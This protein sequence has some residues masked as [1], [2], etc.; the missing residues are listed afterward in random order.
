MV[1]F[2]TVPAEELIEERPDEAQGATRQ[3]KYLAKERSDGAFGS[4]VICYFSEAEQIS[5]AR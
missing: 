2:H 3:M 5:R 1:S 4:I